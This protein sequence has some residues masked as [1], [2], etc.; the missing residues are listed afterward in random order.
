MDAE[1]KRTDRIIRQGMSFLFL[2]IAA[3]IIG[4]LSFYFSVA[5]GIASIF[6][7]FGYLIGRICKGI[8]P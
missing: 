1:T 7:W 3:I 2:I 4:F 8:E 6:F 5:F